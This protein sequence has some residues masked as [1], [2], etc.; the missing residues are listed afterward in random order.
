MAGRLELNRRRQAIL[1]NLMAQ[2]GRSPEMTRLLILMIVWGNVRARHGYTTVV[3]QPVR[4]GHS[5]KRGQRRK[6]FSVKRP[7]E[8][9]L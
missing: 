9:F 2:L 5:R 8:R 7:R 6:S 1:A 4:R 3:E